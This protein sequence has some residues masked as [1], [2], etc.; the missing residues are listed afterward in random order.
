M[1]KDLFIPAF[2][3]NKLSTRK[4]TTKTIKRKGQTLELEFPVFQQK[5]LLAIAESLSSKKRRAHDRSL[6]ELIDIIDQVGSL[7]KDPNFDLRKE[8]LEIIPIISGQ[9][10]RL[11][12][13]EIDG[14]AQLWSKGN[15]LNMLSEDLGGK[16]F[17]EEW[18]PK[19][20]VRLHAQPRGLIVHNLAG[21]S[22]SLSSLSLFYGLVTKNVN[23]IKLS[24]EAPYLGIKWA[25]SIKE[26]D[27]KLAEEFALLY[28]SGQQ[29]ENYNSLFNSRL[30]NGVLAWGGLTSIENIRKQAYQYGIHIIDYGPKLS[31]SILS[32]AALTDPNIMQELANKITYDIVFWNQKAC[33]SPR[34]I[35]IT[36]EDFE[37]KPTKAQQ[38]SLENLAQ[39]FAAVL[40]QQM[41][42]TE[43]IFPRTYQTTG[44][45]VDTLRKREYYL[46]NHELN[47]TGKVFIPQNKSNNW[48]VVYQKN[49]P[50]LDEINKCINRFIIVTPA[51]SPKNIVDFF[52]EK[53]IGRFLQTC[54][55]KGSESFFLN[56]L[57]KVIK[58]PPMII[59]AWSKPITRA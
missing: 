43:Q 22:F 21:N 46:M 38:A 5:E 58:S 3:P 44:E 28:W 19:G 50:N 54:S 34:V 31:F 9:S 7:W 35:Y 14:V 26:V 55:L 53:K 40:A 59:P 37:K 33:L 56:P 1:H 49:F 15:I 52:A 17:L 24:S 42:S 13:F 51:P 2:I 8:S 29:Q 30:V 23:L 6:S 27:K 18:V 45:T 11:C 48:T 12:E 20:P 25:E 32:S 57:K 36:Q 16:E 47:G 39:Q 4:T 10:R 41:E